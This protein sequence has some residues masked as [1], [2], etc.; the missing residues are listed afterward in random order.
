MYTFSLAG[1][2]AGR[3]LISRVPHSRLRA[4][5]R[6]MDADDPRPV[7][8]GGVDCELQIGLPGRYSTVP[9]SREA[10]GR[11]GESGEP[12]LPAI[13]MDKAESTIK[14]SAGRAKVFSGA[15]GTMGQS[16]TEGDA[17]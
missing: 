7:A 17:P 6:V 16:R 1:G 8:D 5:A 12:I 10:A 9:A 4:L 13:V 11:L 15:S 3:A 14:P 2:L